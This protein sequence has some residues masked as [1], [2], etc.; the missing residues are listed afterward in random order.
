M[1]REHGVGERGESWWVRGSEDADVFGAGE[2][3]ERDASVLRRGRTPPC[4]APDTASV[5]FT[6]GVSDPVPVTLFNA[7]STTL[8]AAATS[9]TLTGTSS[10]FTVDPADATHFAVPTPATQTA[11][12]SFN[13]TITALDA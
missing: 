10:S 4:A 11:G 6:A 1:R 9:P 13:E 8:T 2:L 7:A 12:T 3:A 5:T